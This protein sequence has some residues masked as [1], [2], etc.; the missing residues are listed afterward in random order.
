MR[1]WFCSALMIGCLAL[2]AC[3]GATQNMESY[4]E[5]IAQSRD[6]AMTATQQADFGETTEEYTLQYDF[7]GTQWTALVTEPQ[8]VAGITARITKDASELEYDGVILAT[9]DL[10]GGGIAPISAVPLIY[11]ALTV[12]M[13]D[14][15]WE[16]GELLGG[17][18]V[19]DDAISVSVWFDREGN[20]VAA[21]LIEQGIVKAKCIL[22]DV[23]IKEANHG[24]T[25]KTDL[26]GNQPK[27]SGT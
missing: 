13:V 12:G 3:G 27:E 16:E 22:E 11:E 7:D 23:E 9:G 25:E 19:Y 10:T 1:K 18:F 20:P 2:T 24:T 17:S 15:V 26:G 4:C 8:F 5:R 21:E 6:M 14:S